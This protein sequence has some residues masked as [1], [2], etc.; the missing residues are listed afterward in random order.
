VLLHCR[1]IASAAESC[2]V[3]RFTNR[4][5]IAPVVSSTADDDCNNNWHVT[6]P[7]PPDD[8]TAF[9]LMTYDP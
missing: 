6:D 8:A 3:A 9:A 7:T 1:R 2:T 5:E 4:E